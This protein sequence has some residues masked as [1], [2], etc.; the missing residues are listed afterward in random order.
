[1]MERV[2]TQIWVQAQIRICDIRNIPIYVRHKGDPDA[3]TVL[4]KLNGFTEGSII[5]T[6]VTGADRSEW[7]RAMGEAPVPDSYAEAYI[8][9]QLKWDADL[10]VLEIEDP[11]GEYLEL[12]GVI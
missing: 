5:L 3:G 6:Q 1:M 10:W 8:E 4:V 12:F 9:R 11:K 7:M 2:L